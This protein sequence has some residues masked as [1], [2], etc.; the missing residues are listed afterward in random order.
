MF[1]LNISVFV[2]TN[3]AS[4]CPEVSLKNIQYIVATLC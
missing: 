1:G 3:I 2:T 4:S